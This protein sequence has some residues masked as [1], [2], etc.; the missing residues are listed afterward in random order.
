V[1]N[2]PADH[3]DPCWAKQKV[4]K[5]AQDAGICDQH[6]MLPH[7][8]AGARYPFKRNGNTR[9]LEASRQCK[10]VHDGIMLV[11]AVRS[12]LTDKTVADMGNMTRLLPQ[13]ESASA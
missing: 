3:V 9:H 7:D 12:M 10:L 8:Q 6:L 1:V 5:V 13:I 4:E 11:T 2:D